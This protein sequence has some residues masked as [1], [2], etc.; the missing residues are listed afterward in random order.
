MAAQ[1]NGDF[2]FLP[3]AGAWVF[4]DGEPRR[5]M[6][7]RARYYA[8][9]E[10]SEYPHEDHTGE[11]IQFHCCPWCGKDLPKVLLDIVREMD[12]LGDPET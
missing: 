2:I 7:P 10:R 3:H 9:S 1:A 6:S 12:G 11:P 8:F 4:T 5:T